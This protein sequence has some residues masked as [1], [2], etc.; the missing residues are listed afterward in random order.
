MDSR[1][2]SSGRAGTDVALRCRCGAWRGRVRGISPGA[3]YHVVCYCD[4]CQ[5][6]ANLLGTGRETLDAHGG[7]EIFQTSPAR[8]EILQG[9]EYVAC[10]RLTAH[11]PLRWFAKCCNTAIGNTPPTNQVPFIGLIHS[12]LDRAGRSLDEVLGPVRL[13]VMV[14][15][16]NGEIPRTRAYAGFPL[17]YVMRIAFRVLRW[18]LRGEHKTNPFFDARTG[19][20]IAAAVPTSEL[21]A[22]IP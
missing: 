4:D 15:Y 16:A 18:R 8:V 7:T 6:F 20:P 5:R 1:S 12:C 2:S 10:L 19:Q 13:R 14:Q 9:I 3:G 21:T 17:L 22:D 11:G